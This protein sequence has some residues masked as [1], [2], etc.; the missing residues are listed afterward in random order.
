MPISPSTYVN[1][2][3]NSYISVCMQAG[4]DFSLAFKEN[5][6][7]DVFEEKFQLWA[8]SII[9]YCKDTQ[10]R[11]SAVQLE[12]CDYSDDV[13]EGMCFKASCVYFL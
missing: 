11:S 4:I 13:E 8:Q 7:R 1:I 3:Y 10:I 2:A 6:I 5:N 9:M 12:T